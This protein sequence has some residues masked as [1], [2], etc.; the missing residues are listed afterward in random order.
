M[1]RPNS[2]V[3][4]R[5]AASLVTLRMD[6]R[7]EQTF[8]AQKHYDTHFRRPLDDN[9]RPAQALPPFSVLRGGH[10]LARG[11]RLRQVRCSTRHSV[12]VITRAARF[13]S[14][15]H[16]REAVYAVDVRLIDA[17][18]TLGSVSPARLF[19]VR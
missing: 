13:D 10:V 9:T 3:A 8:R 6:I 11:G 2:A 1:N 19:R 15:H 18:R 5:H 7:R 16:V 14:T 12:S 4:R 17:R